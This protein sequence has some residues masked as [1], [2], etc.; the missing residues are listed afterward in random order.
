L[1]FLVRVKWFFWDEPYFLNTVLIRSFN[2]EFLT[3]SSGIS[4]HSIMTK[5]V[6]VISVEENCCKNFVVWFLL[7]LCFMTLMSTTNLVI[8]VND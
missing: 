7:P 5:H 4:F 3:L 8:V 1:R 6:V 2:A